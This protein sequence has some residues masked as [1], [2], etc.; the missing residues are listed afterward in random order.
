VWHLSPEV[1]AVVA[2]VSSY[3][4]ATVDQYYE[5]VADGFTEENFVVNGKSA[6]DYN[7]EQIGRLRLLVLVQIV[8]LGVLAASGLV[9][10]QG[11]AAGA[12]LSR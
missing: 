10:S 5:S 6:L 2:L 7:D 1:K 3:P 9:L 11:K 8:A 4:T 12:G